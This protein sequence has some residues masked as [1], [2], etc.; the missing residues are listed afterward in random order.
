MVPRILNSRMFRLIQAFPVISAVLAGLIFAPAALAVDP[1]N[2]SYLGGVAIRG[3]DPVAY[4]E[5]GMPV[6][7]KKEFSAEWMDATWQFANAAN[8]DKFKAKPEQFAPQFGGYCAY[9]VSYGTTADIDPEAW[10]IVDGKLYLNKNKSI[11]Q[12]WSQ[13]IPG[14]IARANKN[15]PGIR[16]N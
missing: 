16:G 3:Y 15:W 7:G 5:M 8:R 6:E 14:H 11:Q 1:V 12:S 4:F 2:K 10:K 13:D 9:A